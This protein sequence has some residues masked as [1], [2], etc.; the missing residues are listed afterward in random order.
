MKKVTVARKHI[1]DI[2]RDKVWAQ[3][4]SGLKNLTQEIYASIP[5][6]KSA[7]KIGWYRV[8]RQIENKSFRM[9]FCVPGQ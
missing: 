1:C 9:Y 5:C 6:F 2:Y 4:N 8:A 3:V 7:H